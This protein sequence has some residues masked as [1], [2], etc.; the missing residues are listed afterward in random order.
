MNLI[1][2]QTNVMELVAEIVWSGD[3]KEVARKLVFKIVS[4]NTDYYLPKVEIYEGDTVLLQ[5]EYGET[6]FFGLIF[7][8]EKFGSSHTISYTS[9]D[10]LFYLKRY[11]MS[12]VFDAKAETIVSDICL[13]LG[14]TLGFACPTN[15]QIYLPA[16]SETAYDIIMMAYTA[17]SRQNGKKYIPL[18]KNHNEL[19]V[20]EKGNSSGV[21]LDSQYNITDSSYQT[22]I[23]NIVNQV[24]IVDS[25]GATINK[26]EDSK[27]KES[28]GTIQKIY[29]QE[30]DKNAY[31]EA[32]AMI[33]DIEQT[34]SITALS[35]VRAISGYS[36]IVQEPISGLYGLFYIES[37]T[38]TFQNGLCT[39]QLNL[40]FENIMDEKEIKEET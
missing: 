29:K 1:V 35:D 20:I 28:Y 13:E 16:F 23:Q 36:I 31:T 39:M 17:V 14:I 15:I 27:S 22:S 10:F 33:T 5:D 6:L 18:I 7:D 12:R 32:S 4:K 2:N 25:T 34:A 37:D 38:H 30:E 24:L 40:A 21:L 26:I 3:V 11:E 19:H 9:F 8:I